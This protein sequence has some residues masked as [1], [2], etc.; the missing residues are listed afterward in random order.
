MRAQLSIFRHGVN[1]LGSALA[2]KLLPIASIFIFSHMMTV[3]EFGVLSLFT[4][5][6]WIFAITISFNLH[7]ALGRY[8]YLPGGKLPS[9]LGTLLI[10]IGAAYAVGSAAVC[11]IGE[12]FETWTGLPV[13]IAPLLLAVVAGQLAESLLTQWAIYRQESALLM[14]AIAS[15]ATLT[16]VLAI[17]LLLLVPE[18]RYL[19]VAGADALL[20]I[21]M[22]VYVAWVFRKET[23]WTFQRPLLTYALRYSLPLIPYTL[24]IALLAQ[25]DRLMI[26]RIYG[27]EATGLYSLAFN[28]GMLFSLVMTAVLNAINPRFFSDMEGQRYGH[29]VADGRGSFAIALALALAVV[30]LG[31]TVTG[32]LIPVQYQDALKLIP[33]IAIG[34]LFS[35]LFQIWG[36]LLHFHHLTGLLSCIAVACVALKII[37]NLLLLPSWGWQSAALSTIVA[38]S[39]MAVLTAIVVNF[40]VRSFTLPFGLEFAL[41]VSLAAATALLHGLR[42]TAEWEVV[43]RVSVAVAF[44]WPVWT[45]LVGAWSNKTGHRPPTSLTVDKHDE[46]S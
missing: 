11:F 26:D 21:G 27:K 18:E 28:I 35:V 29:V 24:S 17:F 46:T 36:R 14:R 6:I 9:F 2:S 19:A 31:P 34:G 30:L 10:A 8:A 43:A 40:K 4:S 13:K 45:M 38:Y 23:K 22:V 39:A 25:V 44:F 37:V 32:L 1:H 5:Y 20:S 41:C 7:T 15:K 12:Y 33:V 3:A 16:L 42:L